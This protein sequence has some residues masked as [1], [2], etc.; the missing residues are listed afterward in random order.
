MRRKWKYVWALTGLYVLALFIWMVSSQSFSTQ[1][2]DV[3][4][5]GSSLDHLAGT[6]ALGRDRAI[7]ISLA[8]LVSLTGSGIA[9]LVSTSMA[10]LLGI[11]AAFIDRRITAVLFFFADVFL[12]LPWL[13]LLMLVR[14]TIP[15]NITGWESAGMTFLL[16]AA[17]GWPACARA[18]HK[19]ALNLR[20]SEWV[21]QARAAGLRSR[22]LISVAIPNLT[23]ILI[24]QF[25][26]SVPAFIMA[27]ANL[28]SIGL[29]IGEP[30]PS[31]GG[32]L[33]ALDNSSVLMRSYWELLPVVVLAIVL[34]LMESI[35]REEGVGA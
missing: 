33:Q 18:L 28:G 17:L 29:G 8:L 24:V 13:F 16:L 6:D 10:A 4:L 34:L 22:Q 25:I 20:N 14:A 21:L 2:R 9:A 32:M 26:V 31:W 35:G 30:V 19:S 5:G 15:L 11:G 27:E 12:A 1:D 3:L 7:R 23:P